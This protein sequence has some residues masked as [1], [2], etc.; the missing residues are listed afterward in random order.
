MLSFCHYNKS[1]NLNNLWYLKGVSF[2]LS[3][4]LLGLLGTLEN[5]IE[6]TFGVY[7]SMSLGDHGNDDINGQDV[8]PQKKGAC[9][10][11]LHVTLALQMR[12]PSYY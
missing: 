7:V 10:Y 12:I 9:S 11:L 1:L 8:W 2:G 6:N 3:S 5:F 4:S